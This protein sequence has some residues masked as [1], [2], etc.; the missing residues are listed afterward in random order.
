MGLAL[1]S[2]VEKTRLPQLRLS[3]GIVALRVGRSEI[4]ETFRFQGNKISLKS[5]T[6][7]GRL[8]LCTLATEFAV[9]RWRH[10][11]PTSICGKAMH[12]DTITVSVW[13]ESQPTTW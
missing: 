1:S 5:D 7:L 11:A 12:F 9:R 8:I 2:I 3:A 6:N 10:W 4:S 13:A